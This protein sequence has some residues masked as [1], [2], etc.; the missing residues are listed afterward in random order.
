[1]GDRF[2]WEDNIKMDLQELGFDGKNWIELVQYR[3][4]SLAIVN[5]VVNLR[6]P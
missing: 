5:A 1:L 2:R 4:K 3:D 6:I